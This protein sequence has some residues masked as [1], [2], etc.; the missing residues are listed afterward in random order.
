MRGFNRRTEF[1]P[2]LDR[3]CDGAG[4]ILKDEFDL[5]CGRRVIDAGHRSPQFG[6]R[7]ALVGP[8]RSSD[9][10]DLAEMYFGV[11]AE[12]RRHGGDCNG[13]VDRF[14]VGI[15]QTIET[16]AIKAMADCSPRGKAG[17]STQ[18]PGSEDLLCG[19]QWRGD[20]PACRVLHIVNMLAQFFVTCSSRSAIRICE[21]PDRPIDVKA[22]S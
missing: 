2:G 13:K 9:G 5:S 16:L 22:R 8:V 7:G 11:A 12:P 10:P 17:S 20:P 1:S 18:A 6:K 21:Q 14:R 3:D 19:A 15:R 4:G